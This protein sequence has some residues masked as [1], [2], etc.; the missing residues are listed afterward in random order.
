M[1]KPAIHLCL[2]HN[3]AIANISP[4][5]DPDFRPQEVILLY[6]PDKTYRADCLEA[7]LKPTGV[8]VS[9]WT[10]EDPWNLE[11]IRVGF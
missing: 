1:L 10:I 7:V 8:K 4:A 2:L 9:C 6:S 3:T 11:P 5:L